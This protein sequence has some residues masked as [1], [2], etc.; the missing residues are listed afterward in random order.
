[1]N[2]RR[3]V[4]P[5][6]VLGAVVVLAFSSIGCGPVPGWWPQDYRATGSLIAGGRMSRAHPFGQDDTGTD[7]FALTMHGTQ[8]SLLIALIVGLVATG[9]GGLVG[10]TAGWCGGWVSAVLMRLTDVVVAVPLLV[11]AAVI[12]RTARGHG[13]VVLGVALGLLQWYLPARLVRAE[14]LSLRERQFVVAAAALGAGPSWIVRRHLLPAVAGTVMVSAT[15]TV[16]A[17]I[18]LETSLSFLGLGVVPP[19]TSLGQLISR[20]AGA[21]QTRSWLFWW[22]GVFAL[23]IVLPVTLLGDALRDA[24]DP[25]DFR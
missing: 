1:M 24:L 10:A 14:V 8:R 25:R 12:A 9:V 13:V 22:P 15:L 16:A 11:V 18:L 4:G 7:M 2:R 5:A 23:A 21:V 19:D 3:T 6:L 20:H 17:A